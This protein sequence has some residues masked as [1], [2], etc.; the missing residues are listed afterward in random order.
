MILSSRGSKLFSTEKDPKNTPM[1]YWCFTYP[2]IPPSTNRMLLS[3]EMTLRRTNINQK[4]RNNSPEYK[5]VC[6][7]VLKWWIMIQMLQ[8][9]NIGMA[10][11]IWSTI[12]SVCSQIFG[13]SIWMIDLANKTIGH[14]CISLFLQ[15]V[16]YYHTS[17][18]WM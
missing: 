10:A 13:I 14:T 3:T 7:T 5:K 1:E 17:V 12:P 2:I 18:Y 15:S 6:S 4:N 16:Y 11:S 9:S 8:S